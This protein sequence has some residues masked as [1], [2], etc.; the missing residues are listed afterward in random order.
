MSIAAAVLGAM[1]LAAT[2][3]FVWGDP[4]EDGVKDVPNWTGVVISM[5]AG[6]LAL[7]ALL[8]IAGAVSSRRQRVG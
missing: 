7:A 1:L 4:D 3:P 8:G 6:A 2:F 5:G